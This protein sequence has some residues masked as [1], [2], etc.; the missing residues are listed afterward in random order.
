VGVRAPDYGAVT[1]D[2][3]RVALAELR[4]AP[5]L[6][7]VWA[8]WCEPCRQELPALAALRARFAPRG[9]RVVA[10]SVD[11]EATRD[12]IGGL[13]R[14]LGRELEVWHDPDDRASAALGVGA[15]PATLLFDAAGALA[16][17]RDGAITAD[18]PAL[19]AAIARALAP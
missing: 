3:A 1:L 4:G 18:D 7:N 8:T 11:R 13:A 2:G 9:L 14:R 17:R 10:L 12:K 19:L 5:V 15:L 16:W 6:L